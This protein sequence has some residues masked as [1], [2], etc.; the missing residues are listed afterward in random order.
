ML[1]ILVETKSWSNLWR[2]PPVNN[3]VQ[4]WCGD[5]TETTACQGGNLA[6]FPNY[7]S[8]HVLGASY[9]FVIDRNQKL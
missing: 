3:E 6:S 9:T 7:T 4:W 2:C 1:A 5:E 8:G